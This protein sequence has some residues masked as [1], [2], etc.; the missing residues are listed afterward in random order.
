MEDEDREV[1]CQFARQ[2]VVRPKS[3]LPS[4]QG[5]KNE[6]A[7]KPHPRLPQ[8]PHTSRGQSTSAKRCR[9]MKKRNPSLRRPG[10]N[11]TTLHLSGLASTPSS[12]SSTQCPTLCWLAARMEHSTSLSVSRVDPMAEG[13][14]LSS[15]RGLFFRVRASFLSS[16]LRR[17]AAEAHLPV[18]HPRSCRV[19][20]RRSHLL[21][22][23]SVN[24]RAAHRSLRAR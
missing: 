13:H 15:R 10:F 22:P 20:R 7:T 24:R 17:R 1:P 4:V 6:R 23:R 5:R 3:H 2:A 8:T 18:L 12:R 14:T 19:P 16:S 9:C 11:R 21:G